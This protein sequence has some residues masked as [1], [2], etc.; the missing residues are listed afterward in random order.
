MATPQKVEDAV[1][2]ILQD[3]ARP[4][5]AISASTL[6][7]QDLLISGD[8]A[9]E[10]IDRIQKECGTSFQGFP[11]GDYFP[12]ET[13]SLFYRFLHLFGRNSKKNLTVGHL[14]KVV[15]AG[16]WYEEAAGKR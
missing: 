4:S 11:F 16:K 1:L 5:K 2:R 10:L 7:Y 12:D 9:T 15:E 14:L 8:D 13:E 6:I 3:I